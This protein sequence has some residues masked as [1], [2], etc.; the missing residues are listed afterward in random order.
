MA[1]APSKDSNQPGYPPSLIRVFAVHMKEAW[2]LSY[3]L[4]AQRR[5]IRLGRC[6]GWSESLPG[7]CWFCHANALLLFFWIENKLSPSTNADLSPLGQNSR[8]VSWPYKDKKAKDHAPFVSLIQCTSPHLGNIANTLNSLK[9]LKSST[10]PL[11]SSSYDHY[12]RLM[13]RT[14]RKQ[15]LW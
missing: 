9:I 5:L 13:I 14:V 3:R 10:K 15:L 8:N 12:H 6:P 2:V 1:C 7:A 11:N 4:S